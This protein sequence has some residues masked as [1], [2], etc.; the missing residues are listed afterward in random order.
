M[1]V[2]VGTLAFPW[3][4]QAAKGG[5][6]NKA[7]FNNQGYWVWY[8]DPLEALGPN[9]NPPDDFVSTDPEATNDYFVIGAIADPDDQL[10]IINPNQGCL[11]TS[12]GTVDPLALWNDNDFLS[13]D[14][15]AT[16]FPDISFGTILIPSDGTLVTT[17]VHGKSKK[18]RKQS[19]TLDMDVFQIDVLDTNG[20]L[21][22]TF[23]PTE[24][25]PWDP[26]AV[27]RGETA[28]L[29]LGEWR[30]TS[31]KRGGCSALG[32]F[33]DD[34]VTL[35]VKRWTQDEQDAEDLCDGFSG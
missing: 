8:Q 22:Q 18:G 34:A 1:A 21:I 23:F 20:N 3:T 2:V 25:T 19:Y 17:N 16:C 9:G 24:G 4:A 28:V 29:H 5:K 33:S 32:N 15:F 12:I 35:R 7:Q 14:K 27:L 31:S 13:D 10:M 11:S 30:L 6:K 26:L